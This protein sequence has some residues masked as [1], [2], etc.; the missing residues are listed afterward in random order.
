MMHWQIY[1]DGL[2]AMLLFAA[3]GWLISLYRNNVTHVDSMWSLFF[4]VAAGAYVCGLETMNLRGSLM[5][6]LL[7]IWALR[8]FVYLTWRNWGPHEDHRYV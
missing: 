2:V 5:V 1:L 7:T 4:L 8:L 6:G 3:L